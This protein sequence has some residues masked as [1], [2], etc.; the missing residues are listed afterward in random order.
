MKTNFTSYVQRAL[1][2]RCGQ[3]L[4]WVA[5]ALVGLIGMTGLTFDVG[6]ALNTQYIIGNCANQAALAAAGEVYTSGTGTLT[7][8]A[9]QY[10]CTP[11][12]PNYNPLAG[13]VTTTVTAVCL[14]LLEPAGTTC[15]ENNNVANAVKVTETVTAPT[16]FMRALGFN[17]I[18]MSVT[19]TASMQGTSNPWNVAIIQDATGSMA[20]TD[21][22]CDG[23]PS[24]FQCA[25]YGIQAF[26]NAVSPN[27]SNG[28]VSCSPGL[29]QLRIA[30]FSFPNMLSADLP[31]ANACSG[32]TF[33]SPLPYTVYTLP[34]PT[35]TSYIPLTYTQG[36][37]NWT[38][39]YEFT[40]GASDA[41]AN[42][43]VADWSLPSSTTTGGLNPASSLVMAVGYNH[44]A[45]LGCMPI[46]PGGIDLNGATGTPGPTVLV[47][48][49]NVGEGITY[50]ASVI[51]AAQAA[52]TAEAALYP[53][54]KTVNAI[55]ISSDGQAN[56]QW[57]YFPQGTITS[58]NDTP[59][60][61]TIS[62]TLGYSTLNTVPSLTAVGAGYLTTPNQEVAAGKTISGVYP[63]FLDEC[64]QA[65]VAAQEATLAGTRVYSVAYGSEDSGCGTGSHADDYTDVTTVTLP[66]TPNVAWSGAANLTPCLTM[67]NMA[68]T[69]NYFYSDHNQSG[70]GVDSSCIS[71]WNVTQLTNIY[72]KIASTMQEPKL[73]PNSAT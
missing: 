38:A 15:A 24:E 20:D 13:N 36:A 9:T 18:P 6:S 42:G 52:L 1:L 5:L 59:Q 43:F 40:Y 46:S 55:I 57:I 35:A 33:V 64:Q 26:L 14:N 29:A 37:T 30:L 73:L 68:S 12:N 53:N 70:S 25:L 19:A 66:S 60:A 48:H 22:D 41:D 44:G 17:S 3:V 2:D 45:H 27:C 21:S 10:S 63:D 34:L 39:S 56:T 47:N 51:Y 32:Q 11:G 50:Y 7:S 31:V 28:H 61:S 69:I 54:P 58:P 49:A 8:V 65:I 71:P 16:Y 23:S 62:A 67:E 72:Q 4:P